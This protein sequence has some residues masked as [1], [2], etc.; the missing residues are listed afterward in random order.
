MLTIHTAGYEGLN[1]PKFFELL[2][3]CG[4]E[5]LVDVRDLPI[6]RK[7]GFSKA[8][9]SAHCDTQEIE[10]RHAAQLGCPREVRH[11][12]RV[13]G[14]WARYTVRYKAYLAGQAAALTSV[15]A[16]AERRRICL[17]CFEEDFNLCHRT[18]VAEALALV[19]GGEVTISHL[20]GPI[21]GRVVVLSESMAA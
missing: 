21:K 20:T 7:P 11:A 19:I 18:Y 6:S 5:V 15:A 12:Y 3:R 17:L 1:A 14:D 4:I 10:Y 16:L 8:A 13:D 2:N 9:L